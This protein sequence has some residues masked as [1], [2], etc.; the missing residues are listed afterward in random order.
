MCYNAGMA[1][2]PDHEAIVNEAIR[3]TSLR[4]IAKARGLTLS[5]V[6]KMVDDEAAQAFNGEQ[7]RREWLYEA[8]RLRELGQRYYDKAMTDAE[9]ASS[10]AIIFL[11]A[12][13]R[14]ATLT[15]MNPVQGHAVQLIHSTAPLSRQ[16]STEQIRDV[17]DNILR[18][19]PRE[20]ELTDRLELNGEDTPE[21]RAEIEQL[22][23]ARGKLPAHVHSE[24]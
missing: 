13:E 24:K 23:A 18:I 1:E 16:T 17:L 8:R 3:G 6:R 20:R 22:Q 2:H 12:S 4:K 7:L 10:S 11:K 14:L 9:D 5:D 19:T 21:I 15:G